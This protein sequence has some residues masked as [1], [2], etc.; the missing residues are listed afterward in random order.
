MIVIL[1]CLSRRSSATATLTNLVVKGI[2]WKKGSK[3]DAASIATCQREP[4]FFVV[5][6]GIKSTKCYGS[7]NEVTDLYH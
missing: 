6:R 3:F 1:F 2:S 7:H 5:L 4:D